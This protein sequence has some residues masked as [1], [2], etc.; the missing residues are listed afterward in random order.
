MFAQN[1]GKCRRNNKFPVK[2]TQSLILS[3]LRSDKFSYFLR[4]PE[5]WFP[6]KMR[7]G[8][9]EH[10]KAVSL[11]GSKKK[12]SRCHK[13]HRSPLFLRDKISRG[14]FI[15]L[16]ASVSKEEVGA[17]QVWKIGNLPHR[18]HAFLW[19]SHP[20]AVFITRIIEIFSI[21][22]RAL[23]ILAPRSP[24]AIENKINPAAVYRKNID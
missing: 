13:A 21:L 6:W 22:P 9:L 12:R 5:K 18:F 15:C 24:D 17:Q 3:F 1:N 8:S 2:Y 14:A 23:T 4:Q 19:V 7:Q 20:M 16:E 11:S 10:K